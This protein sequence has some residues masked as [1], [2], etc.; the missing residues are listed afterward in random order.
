MNSFNLIV[1]KVE[2]LN[3]V[4]WLSSSHVKFAIWNSLCKHAWRSLILIKMQKK[5]NLWRKCFGF[6]FLLVKLTIWNFSC[7]HFWTIVTSYLKKLNYHLSTL[8][9][10][11]R[12]YKH[13]WTIWTSWWKSWTIEES[14]L[15][16][17]IPRKNHHLK[18][19]M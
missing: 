19:L 17:I 14:P 18:L 8:P 16:L 5:L 6:T 1:K 9:L 2:S 3:T 15:I 13:F 11:Y 10:W 4:F 7:K 12:S